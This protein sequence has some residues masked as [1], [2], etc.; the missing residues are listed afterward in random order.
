MTSAEIVL[1]IFLGLL[2]NE[3]CDVS[4][5]LARKVVCWSAYRR[6]GD[7]E[8]AAVRTEELTALIDERPGKLLKLITALVF[9]VAAAL[10]SSSQRKTHGRFQ[11][12]QV[13]LPAFKAVKWLWMPLVAGPALGFL[14][15]DWRIGTIVG[16]VT[17]VVSWIRHRRRA[18]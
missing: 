8:R 5:W 18:S 10:S 4:P 12:L 16:M 13:L 17:L 9:A 15:R 3:A 2:V 11:G 14:V 7:A 1:A 6:Y